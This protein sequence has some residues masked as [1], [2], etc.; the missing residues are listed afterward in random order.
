MSKNIFFFLGVIVGGVI[1]GTFLSK[2]IFL[3]FPENQ[4]IKD[5]FTIEKTFGFNPIVLNLEPL[6][7]TFGLQLKISF[8]VFLGIILALFFFKRFLK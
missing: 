5:V 2:V 6:I 7:F 4:K 1:L 8:M 3:L